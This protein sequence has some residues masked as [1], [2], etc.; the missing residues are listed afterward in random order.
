MVCRLRV[1][2]EATSAHENGTTCRLPRLLFLLP[3]EF[4]QENCV[5]LTSFELFENLIEPISV[6]QASCIF[7]VGCQRTSQSNHPSF[8]LVGVVVAAVVLVVEVVVVVL[9][10]CHRPLLQYAH[11]HVTVCVREHTASSSSCV[12]RMTS[13]S[14]NI[15]AFHIALVVTAHSLSC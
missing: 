9:R 15:F 3:P 2:S 10:V 11:W 4:A 7:F 13:R 12:L 5:T 1:L 14:H 6:F 8:F